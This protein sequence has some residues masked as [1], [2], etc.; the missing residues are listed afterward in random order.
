[1]LFQKLCQCKSDWDENIPKQLIEEWKKL[2]SELDVSLSISLPRSYL[3]ELRAPLTSVTLCGFCDA[4]TKAYAAV[5]YLL[6]KTEAQTSVRFVAAKTRVAPL[7][8]QTIPRLELLSAYLLSKLVV[9][10][11]NSLQ[12][13]MGPLDIQCYTDSQV[14]LY[15]VCGIDKEWR[16]FVQN[17]VKEIRRNVHPNHWHHCPGITNPADLPSRGTTIMELAASQMWHTGPEWLVLDTPICDHSGVESLSMP[18]LCSQELKSANKLSHNLLVVDIG[19]TIGDLMR[20]EDFSDLRS[21]LRVT[22]YVRRAVDR[23]K[24]RQKSSDSAP[25]S[26]LKPQEI[27]GEERMWISHAQKKLSQQKDFNTLKRQL[28]LFQDEK[29]LWR[30]GGRL[31]NAKIPYSARHPVLLPRSCPFTA[32]VVHDAHR[33]VCHNG[34]KET[35]TEVRSRFWIVKGRSLARAIIHQARSMKEHHL[36]VHHHF[37]YQSSGSR[38]TQPLRI[39]V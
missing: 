16:P 7:Q 2:I 15:W 24:C 20:C 37:L 21:L 25:I 38:K 27:A 19:P 6:L 4:S 18:E 33:R 8:G 23:F 5:V 30:C 29:G 34:V 22:A 32:L 36:R 9:S 12:H 11:R 28:G 10:V 31:Q 39:Q 35:L 26:V 1:M 3:S 13:V 14:A 17:R